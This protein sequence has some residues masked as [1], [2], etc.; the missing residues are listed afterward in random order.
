MMNFTILGNPVS[1]SKSPDLFKAAYPDQPELSYDSNLPGSPEEC[2]KILKE[3]YN[4]GNITAPFKEGVYSLADESSE[5]AS[6][7]GAANMAIVSKGKIKVDNSDHYGV[8]ES[9]KEFG[10]D[11]RNKSCLLLGIGGAG[12]AAAFALN[13]AGA[14]LTIA[15]RTPEKAENYAAKLNSK[16]ISISDKDFA[17]CV[18][19]SE[20][21]VNTLYS[22]IDIIDANMLNP[23]QVILD[24]SYI[25]SSLLEKA[26]KINCLTIDGRY[27]VY[28]QAVYCFKIFTGIE[29]DKRAMRKIVNID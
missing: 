9:F 5:I 14:K 25:G 28:H 3:N 19:N 23:N 8:I 22:D 15:N 24:A 26:K 17:K 20:I 7:I 29:P 12:K 13:K 2:I 10:I 27:W 1:H 21:I 6:F 4:G 11:L 18:R 16:A